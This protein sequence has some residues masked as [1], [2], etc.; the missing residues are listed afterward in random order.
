[1]ALSTRPGDLLAGRYRLIDLLSESGGGRFWRAHDRVLERYVALHVIAEDDPRAPGLIDAARASATVLDPRILRVLDAETRD[2][3]CYVV[4][5]WGTGTSLDLLLANHGPVGPRRA[6]W[7]VA[8]V[9]GHP[10][11]EVVAVRRGQG[12]V[13]QEVA[14][15]VIEDGAGRHFLQPIHQLALVERAAVERLP[16][17]D[18]PHELEGRGHG[19]L[20]SSA[21]GKSASARPRLSKTR[22]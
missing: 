10:C 22:P 15:R 3:R 4:N 12:P 17:L 5:E 21:T 2:G 18:A 19:S 11:R 7:L 14:V 13:P 6:A 20:E 16:H 1:M 9:A 8:D